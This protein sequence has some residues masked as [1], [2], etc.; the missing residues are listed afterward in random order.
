MNIKK[1]HDD[2]AAKLLQ[3]QKPN[4]EKQKSPF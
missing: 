3:E 1:A 4:A 2:A